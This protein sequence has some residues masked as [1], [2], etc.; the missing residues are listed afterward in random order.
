MNGER[1]VALVFVLP[2]ER[3]FAL[4]L[5]PED[6]EHGAI[7]EQIKAVTHSLNADALTMDVHLI[8]EAFLLSIL[9]EI[10]LEIYRKKIFQC[11]L[12]ASSLP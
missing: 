11:T 9:V 3:I 7:E 1:I 10:L 2:C 6:L 12:T 8:N 5:L 4:L